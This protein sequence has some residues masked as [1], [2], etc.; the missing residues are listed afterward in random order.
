MLLFENK[1][2][3]LIN[4]LKFIGSPFKKFVST[5]E[6]EEDIGLVQSRQDFLQEIVSIIERNENFILPIIGDVGQGKTHLY[7]ALKHE[8]YNYNI[9]YISLETVYKRFYYNTYAEFI[10]NLGEKSE[11]R[12]E[13]LRNMTKRLCNEWD[14]GERRFGFFQIADTEEVRKQAYKNW[15]KKF[16]DKEALMEVITAITAHQCDPYKKVEAE[17]WLIGDLMDV[18]DLSRLNLKHDLRKRNISFTMLKVLIENLKKESV[19]FIDDFERII[20]IKKPAYETSDDLEEIEEV[21]DPRWFG[22]KQTPENYSS[23]KVLDKIL[24]LHKIRGLRIIITL[25]S[26]EYLEEIKR[27]IENK[28]RKLLLM[29]K[30][31]LIMANFEEEDVIRSYKNHLDFFFARINYYDYSK[32]FSNSFFPLTETV[33]KYIFHETKGNPREVLKYFIKIFNEIIRSSEKLEDIL[34]KYQ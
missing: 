26:K 16:E 23:D 6:I 19:L 32:H 15:S 22:V 4:I 21:F 8:L 31:P 1:E 3:K 17:R 7:W 10:E 13:P 14:I 33:L 18:R 20:S 5:G 27:K 24:E 25:K 29:V 11:D 30:K 2:Q 9:V 28:D 12:V 34:T